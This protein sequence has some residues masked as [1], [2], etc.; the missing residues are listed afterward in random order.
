MTEA[1]WHSAAT[2]NDLD[3]WET[4]KNQNRKWR[5]F[6]AACCDRAVKSLNDP[7]LGP[8]LLALE[9]YVDWEISWEEM[10]RIRKILSLIRKEIGLEWVGKDEQLHFTASALDDATAKAS[11]L[12]LNSFMSVQFAFASMGRGRKDETR[13][14]HSYR[15]AEERVQ[16]RLARDIFGNPFR[17]V[18]FDS[19]WRSSTAV[20]I[21]ERMY[22]SRDFGAMPILADSLQDAGCEDDA[23]LSH[24]RDPKQNHVRGCWVVD[25]VLGKS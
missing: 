20:G 1:Q 17:P 6:A 18:A 7:R 23:I 11:Q 10:K 4:T 5:L 24:C 12:A 25:L 21:A 14:M 19:R 3:L 22:E 16:L 2:V 8:V 13:R 9:Q 15:A